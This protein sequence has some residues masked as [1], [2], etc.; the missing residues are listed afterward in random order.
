MPTP[1]N[2]YKQIVNFATPIALAGLL[3]LVF[4]ATDQIVVGRFSGYIAL[5]AVGTNTPLIHI[6]LGL[7]VGFSIGVN[8]LASIFIGAKD[9]EGFRRTV[10]TTL[11]VSFIFGTLIM[12]FGLIFSKT[13]LRWMGTPDDVINPATLYLRIICLG[14][15]AVAVF[16]AF[17]A[18]LRSTGDT[19]RPVYCLVVAGVLNV[20][21]NLLFI[22]VFKMSVAGVAWATI[23]SQFFSVVLIIRIMMR[24]KS[25][26]HLD[27][28]KLHISPSEMKRILYNGLPAGAQSAIF[29][30]ANVVIQSG[31]NTFG[32]TVVA[33]ASASSVCEGFCYTV[34]DAV[35]QTCVTF[36]SRN[37]GAGDMGGVRTVVRKCLTCVTIVGFVLGMTLVVNGKFLLGFFS[38]DANVVNAGYLRFQIIC[39]PYL[40]CGIMNVTANAIRSIGYSIMP[41]IVSLLGSCVL[42]IIWVAFIFPLYPTVTMLY[43]CFPI[44][45]T[46]T[47]AI[48]LSI[49]AQLKNKPAFS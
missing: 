19:K 25:D 48:H 14:L 3:Q 1:D 31:V 44:S 12:A 17:A 24:E 18:L 21:L 38:P 34:M 15:P 2:S 45:W 20:C 13:I 43:L 40:I 4:N 47:A 42:R 28:R 33:G 46:V 36:A 39:G 22:I 11:P 5:A 6:L 49:F 8:I 10:N 27:F 26:L 29:N 16:N 41:T 7:L 37:Y 9:R 32:A 30:I 23:I 35:A